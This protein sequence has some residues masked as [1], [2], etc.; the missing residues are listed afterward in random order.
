MTDSYSMRTAVEAVP[1]A[2]SSPHWQLLTVPV[3]AKTHLGLLSPS[4][5]MH[6]YDPLQL[7]QVARFPG[8][9]AASI[10]QASTVARTEGSSPEQDSPSFGVFTPNAVALA[11]IM[12]LILFV[13]T[14][15]SL[16]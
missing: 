7:S 6:I 5:V 12:A 13:R 2:D 11:R 3:A 9:F 10:L 4:A 1:E 8:Q 15:L 14:R 16:S